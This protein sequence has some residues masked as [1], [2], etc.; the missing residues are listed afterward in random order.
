ML[1]QRQVKQDVPW[2]KMS[3]FMGCG[4]YFDAQMDDHRLNIELL[5]MARQEGALI[6]NYTKVTGV[7]PMGAGVGIDLLSNNDEVSSRHATSVIMATGAWNNQFSSQP[8]VK[9]TKGFISYCLIWI[10]RL[11][12]F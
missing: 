2:L 10:Y 8:I 4:S 3:N 5:M 12:C 11:H 1:D 6:Q 9:P 7:H